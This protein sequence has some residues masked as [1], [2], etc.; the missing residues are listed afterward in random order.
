MQQKIE[1]MQEELMKVQLKYQK[2]LEKLERENK[3]LRKQLLLKGQSSS[4]N[5]KI[6]VRF[7]LLLYV[8]DKFL[9]RMTFFPISEVFDWHVL[10]S[11]RRT[12]W[13]RRGLQYTRSSTTSCRRRWPEFR[14]DFSPRN[15][16]AGSHIPSVCLL[17]HTSSFTGSQREIDRGA[18]EMMTRAPV[19]VTL[20]EGPYHIAQFKESSREFDLGKESDLSDLRKEVY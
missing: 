15:D 4:S 16:C 8:N 19:K 12:M 5:R 18:G 11:P 9:A 6:K 17:H 1:K 20:S 2:E 13:L 3:E 14:Q 10:G 7:S